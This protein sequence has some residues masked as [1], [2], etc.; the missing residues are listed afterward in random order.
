MRLGVHLEEVSALTSN[1]L[2]AVVPVLYGLQPLL[3]N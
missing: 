3:Q 2:P 1:G